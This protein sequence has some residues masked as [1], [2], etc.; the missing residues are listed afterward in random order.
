MARFSLSA[1]AEEDLIEI[2]TFIA[3]DSPRAADLVL[4]R[5]D[6]VIRLLADNPRIGPSRSELAETMRSFPSGGYLL[7]YRE[8]PDGVEIVRVV[9]GGRDLPN[10]DFGS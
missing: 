4:D 6:A 3:Q 9:R 1:L 5:I 7:L 2:W 8:T 10:L